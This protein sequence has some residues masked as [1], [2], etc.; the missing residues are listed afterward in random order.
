[1]TEPPST[2]PTPE[3]RAPD[4]DPSLTGPPPTPTFGLTTFVLEGRRAPA[5]F[6]VGWVGLLAGVALLTITVLG[7]AGLAAA[8]LAIG[9]FAALSI[10]TIL[11]AGSQTLE[12]KA[13]GARYAG[14]SPVLVF[15]AVVAT[16]NLLAFLVGTALQPIGGSLPAGLGDL[17]QVLLQ[18]AVFLGI[19]RL[20]AF[21]PGAIRPA[22]LGL[23]RRPRA[24]LQ[25]LAVGAV[26]AAPVLL[27]ASFV[28]AL[29]VQLVGA[30]PP[31]P[32]PPT[33]TPG[34]LLLHLVAGAVI[35]PVY[36][37]VFFRGFALTAWRRTLGA[38]AAIG[39]SSVLFV[40]AHVLSVGGETFG[41]AIT[42]AFVAGIVRM[43]VALTLGWLYVRS[44]SLW[45]PIG[46]HATYNGVLILV[47]ELYLQ[48]ATP[49]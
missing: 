15:L 5:L 32:L 33:G 34:G 21:G 46:L 44:G 25:T 30:E 19:L 6:V 42:L 11:L 17:V 1:M 40:L 28:A 36:E 41:D 29:T 47:A 9:G 35:A 22:E 26:Y 7:A 24:M 43:P 16:S 13:E 18:A 39:L 31:S 27:I 48:S 37:E 12:R 4:A 3:D 38:G 23:G 45:A 49:A 10:G 14:P 8:V 2:G 20:T